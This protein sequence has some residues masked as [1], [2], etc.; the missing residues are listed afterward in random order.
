M[1]S[2]TKRFIL[3]S[4]DKNMLPCMAETGRARHDAA[5]L[6]RTLRGPPPSR[7]PSA[8]LSDALPPEQQNR[9]QPG[10]ASE[11]AGRDERERDGARGRRPSDHRVV[12]VD[13]P[14]R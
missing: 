4:K 1:A 9:S 7:R 10:S 8:T 6:L 14:T 11:P 12:V 5:Y 3:P 13:R 2:A